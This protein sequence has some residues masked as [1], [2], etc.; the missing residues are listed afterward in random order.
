MEGW[1]LEW[2]LWKSSAVV[3]NICCVVCPQ[4]SHLLASCWGLHQS[5]GV[6]PPTFLLL[7]RSV[8]TEVLKLVIAIHT[9]WVCL[10][11]GLTPI[12]EVICDIL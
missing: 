11:L 3:G 1:A 5:S 7:T 10:M 12:L 8:F 9:S 4:V 2:V 6:P